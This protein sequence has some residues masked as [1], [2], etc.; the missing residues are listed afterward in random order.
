MA[1]EWEGD[2]EEISVTKKN[3]RDD[4]CATIS[5]RLEVSILRDL[6]GRSSAKCND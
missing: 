2:W 1:R 4:F 5:G 3:W 6:T